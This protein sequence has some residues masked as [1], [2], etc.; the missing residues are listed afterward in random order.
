M[1][2]CCS[3]VDELM[4]ELGHKHEPEVWY[5]FINFSKLCVHHNGDDLPFSPLVHA[6]HMKESH[7]SMNLLHSYIPYIKY[8]WNMCGVSQAFY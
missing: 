1:V 5:L 2:I 6:L 4:R 7:A 8:F 3:S